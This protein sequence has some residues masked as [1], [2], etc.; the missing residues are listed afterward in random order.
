MW[1]EYIELQSGKG[2]VWKKRLGIV[3]EFT[4]VTNSVILFTCMAM[5]KW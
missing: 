2:D 4:H 3:D 1:Q 5:S